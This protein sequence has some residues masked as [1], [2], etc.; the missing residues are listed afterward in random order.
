MVPPPGARGTSDA[1]VARRELDRINASMLSV[2]DEENAAAGAAAIP[3]IT[4]ILPRLGTA[5]DSAWAYLYLVTAHGMMERPDRACE[6]FRRA[7]RLAK[8]EHQL[9][10]AQ[11]RDALTCAP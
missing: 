11:F 3:R 9:A 10:I 2:P 1:D 6:P 7:V 8:P 4:Q 5:S